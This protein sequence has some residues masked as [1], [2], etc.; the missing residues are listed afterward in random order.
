[1]STTLPVNNW[2]SAFLILNNFGLSKKP[3]PDQKTRGINNLF[4]L[5]KATENGNFISEKYLLIKKNERAIKIGT[6]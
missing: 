2:R 5:D 6:V 3:T 1:V 4:I